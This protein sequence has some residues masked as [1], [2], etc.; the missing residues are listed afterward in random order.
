MTQCDLFVH[1]DDV[2]FSK[3]SVQNRNRLVDANNEVKWASVPIE[4]A[5]ARQGKLS[6]TRIASVA[7][8][9][10]YLA[11]LDAYR[12]RGAKG[13]EILEQFEQL[14]SLADGSLVNLNVAITELGQQSLGCQTPT[15]YSSLLEVNSSKSERIAEI[16][17]RVGAST[18]VAGV[19]SVDYLKREHFSDLGIQ[20]DFTR[21]V[22][23]RARM[24]E[25]NLSTFH[26]L[27]E[28]PHMKI[29]ELGSLDTWLSWE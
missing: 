19:K 21:F 23:N 14:I 20:V 11:I 22:P 17:S 3:G 16:C 27:F 24:R 28:E 2:P 26:F 8:K 13:Q 12:R 25:Y 5:S 1:L 29:S 15:T 18:Y 4:R 6:T 7:W 9:P 10:R